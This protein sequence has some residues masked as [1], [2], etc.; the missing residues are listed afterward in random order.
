MQDPTRRKFLIVAGASAVTAAAS[1]LLPT[2]SAA[3]ATAARPHAPAAAS[4]P[5]AP[6]ALAY[7][8][9]ASAGQLAVLVGEREVV[10][11][12]PVAVAAILTAAR[13]AA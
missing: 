1:P 13:A 11:H 3:P 2:A 10:V 6:R 5:G 7:V 4:S 9:D 12:D 8:K